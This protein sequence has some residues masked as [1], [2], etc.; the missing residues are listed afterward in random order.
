MVNIIWFIS[1]VGLVWV[2]FK[3][4]RLPNKQIFWGSIATLVAAVIATF[5]DGQWINLIDAIAISLGVGVLFLIIA[6][7]ARGSFGMGDVKFAPLCFFPI[8]LHGFLPTLTAMAA[9]FMLA[10]LVGLVA[11]L[12]KRQGLKYKIPFGPFMFFGVMF[13]LVF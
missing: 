2:D 1:C 11:M 9:S 8:A 13:V 10:A 4:K 5:I 12:L 7:L 6:L 3:T